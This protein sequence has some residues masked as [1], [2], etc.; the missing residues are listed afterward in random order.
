MKYSSGLNQSAWWAETN[1]SRNEWCLLVWMQTILHIRVFQCAPMQMNKGK[2]TSLLDFIRWWVEG[3]E[4]IKMNLDSTWEVQT[5]G[6][7][8]SGFLHFSRIKYITK[9][10]YIAAVGDKLLQ[11]SPILYRDLKVI[12]SLLNHPSKLVQ[13]IR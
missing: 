13:L 10:S 2:V 4:I 12:T 7:K 1:C 6:G 5:P 8:M 11:S 3:G 9:L